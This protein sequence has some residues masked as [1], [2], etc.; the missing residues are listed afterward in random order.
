MATAIAQNTRGSIGFANSARRLH[1]RAD[2]LR[3]I[4]AC[5]NAIC[6]MSLAEP[7]RELSNSG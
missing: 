3:F 4:A 7:G 5:A 2:R 1:V 6:P